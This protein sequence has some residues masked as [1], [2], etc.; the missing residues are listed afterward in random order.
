MS[1]L[2]CYTKHSKTQ[3]LKNIIHC[4]GPVCWLWRLTAVLAGHGSG[5]S[6][7]CRA[8]GL[9]RTYQFLILLEPAAWLGC[10]LLMLI[11]GAQQSKSSYRRIFQVLACVPGLRFWRRFRLRHG[12]GM[13][14]PFCSPAGGRG[15]VWD[16]V[17][18]GGRSKVY[19]SSTPLGHVT[20]ALEI[21]HLLIVSIYL[22]SD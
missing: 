9:G 16:Y 12:Q 14:H 2:Q 3:W 22:L 1:I 5:S 11:M 20:S 15:K 8:P 17:V 21:Y 6:A 7:W 4:Q 18:L 19:G 10:V 13:W